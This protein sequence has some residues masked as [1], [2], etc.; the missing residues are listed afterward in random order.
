MSSLHLRGVQ[1]MLRKIK[2]KKYLK[3][4]K[5]TKNVRIP[6][7]LCT[8]PILYFFDVLKNLLELHMGWIL[9]KW[10]HYILGVFKWC[11]EKSYYKNT[12]KLKKG[13]KNVRNPYI[14]RTIPILHF[15]KVLKKFWDFIWLGYCLNELITLKGCSNDA[16]KNQT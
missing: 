15:F 6:Y 14:L 5:G 7:I 2:L 3:I 16:R 10:V 12:S 8:F 13:T 9:F 1:M 4:R 11:P